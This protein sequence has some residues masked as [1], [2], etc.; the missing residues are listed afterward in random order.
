MKQRT[1]VALG[2]FDG[3]HKGHMTV[4]RNALSSA[5][6][7]LLPYVLLFDVHP[8]TVLCG[9]APPALM[10]TK[11]REDTLRAM[12]FTLYTVPFAEICTMEPER[13]VREILCDAL[14]A[15]SVSCGYNYRFGKNGR[16]DAALL[17][18]LCAEKDI[19]LTVSAHIDYAGRPISSTRIRSAVESGK[20]AEANAMLG[21][22]FSYTATVLHGN[23]F[24]RELGF[25]T[26]NQQLPEGYTVPRFGVYASH[27]SLGGKEYR[28]ITNIGV[29]PTI[30]DTT[31]ISETHI[32]DFSGDLYGRCVTVYLDSFIRPEQKFADLNAVFAQVRKD[33][34]TAYGLQ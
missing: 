34:A 28:G 19:R 6:D 14:H 31:V 29:R 25:P 33:I 16:G 11:E 4:L 9:E 23:A 24:G 32:L 26:I 17:G 2:S 18:T 21:R 8:Q 10:T 3:L 20:I 27:V 1:S 7:G 13:F 30:P 5:D 22:A 12:G 15:G